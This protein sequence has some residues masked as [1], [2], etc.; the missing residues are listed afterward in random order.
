YKHDR[1]KDADAGTEPKSG[2]YKHLMN[3]VSNMLPFV[4]GGGILIALSFFWGINAADPNSPE[5][6]EF[7]AM[8]STIGGGTAFFLMVP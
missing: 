4:V 3:G 2:F 8:L 7:A 5:Y 6:N 1:T